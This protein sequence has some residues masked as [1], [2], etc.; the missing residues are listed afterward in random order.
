MSSALDIAK[1]RFEALVAHRKRTRGHSGQQLAVLSLYKRLL[2]VARGK[3]Q[4]NTGQ[5]QKLIRHT[6]QERRTIPV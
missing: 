3:D 4:N 2:R 1:Q 5:M 6:F